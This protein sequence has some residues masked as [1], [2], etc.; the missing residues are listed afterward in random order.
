MAAADLS[1]TSQPTS[2]GA[3]IPA[4]TLIVLRDMAGGPPDLLMVQRAATMAFAGGAW[5]FPGGRVDPGDRLLAA[6]IGFGAADEEDLAA[7][8]AAIRETIEETG[9][10]IGLMPAPSPATTRA[11]QTRLLAG[12]P[13]AGLL[14]DSGLA[15]D[16]HALVPFARWVPPNHVSRRF[17]TRFYLARA[18][19]IAPIRVDGGESVAADWRSAAGLLADWA[20]G[21][22]AIV[23]PTRCNLRRLA[24]HDSFD[25]A[26][27]AATAVPVRILMPTH[28]VIDGIDHARIP[29]GFG[30]P[31]IVERIEA[32]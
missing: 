31:E 18:P 30:Y 11:L 8:I 19:H 29:A 32:L 24:A 14:A 1:P 22:I 16:P 7:R 20:D 27:A 3:P 13:F 2:P 28:E 21:E 12:Q 26:A 9:I 23:F 10:A 5:V 6:E 4:A 25:A 15:I 17:D